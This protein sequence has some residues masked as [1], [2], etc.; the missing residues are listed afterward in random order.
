MGRPILLIEDD[1]ELREVMQLVL[2]S[3]GFDVA[4]AVDGLEAISLLANGL[5]P[6]VILLDLMLPKLDGFAFRERAKALADAPLIVVSAL[7]D[8]AAR[9]QGLNPTAWFRKPVDLDVLIA[10][11]ARLVH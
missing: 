11:V 8:L 6:S 3:Q 4:C 5:R 1:D 9:V 10:A 2:R 7:D